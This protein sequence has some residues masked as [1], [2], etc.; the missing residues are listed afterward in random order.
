MAKN[1]VPGV[2]NLLLSDE[3]AG[4]QAV[5]KLLETNLLPDDVEVVDGRTAG[6]D[7]LYYLEGVDCLMIIDAV[8][9][10]GPPGS[11]AGITGDKEKWSSGA[12]SRVPWMLALI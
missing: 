9:T 2:G 10:G 12:C 1:L 4:I 3:G 6:L 11:M 5:R 8:E 7:V